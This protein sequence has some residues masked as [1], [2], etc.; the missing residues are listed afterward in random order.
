MVD[1][2]TIEPK[3]SL[4]MGD[5]VIVKR[6]A[7]WAFLPAIEWGRD[8]TF[9][10]SILPQPNLDYTG[11]YEVEGVKLSQI[12]RVWESK[13]GFDKYL[14]N[15]IL[16]SEWDYIVG[17]VFDLDNLQA[18]FKV[19][20]RAPKALVETIRGFIGHEDDRFKRAIQLAHVLH[21]DGQCHL[22]FWNYEIQINTSNVDW[23]RLAQMTTDLPHGSGLNSSWHI[24]VNG[25]DDYWIENEYTVMLDEQEI[26]YSVS[27]PLFVRDEKWILGSSSGDMEYDDWFLDDLEMMIEEALNAVHR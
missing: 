9:P 4:A 26:T 14:N 3:D 18:K 23:E 27:W 1:I 25:V 8:F 13:T 7:T 2:F 17:Q 21:H 12:L 10:S 22:S 20:Y 6:K 24:R 15:H 11:Y 5:T 16:R 19:E